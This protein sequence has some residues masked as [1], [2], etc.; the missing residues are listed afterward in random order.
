MSFENVFKS[1]SHYLIKIL[2]SLYIMKFLLITVAKYETYSD[3]RML[4]WTLTESVNPLQSKIFADTENMRKR[5]I[6]IRLA[7]IKCRS[8]SF[9][10]NNFNK[11][12]WRFAIV[13]TY[14]SILNGLL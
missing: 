3:T 1:S 14:L 10:I 5:S 8:Y 11:F 7:S 12:L 9:S 13:A 6:V 4:N 2:I